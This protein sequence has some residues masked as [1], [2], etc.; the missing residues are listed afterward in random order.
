[1]QFQV[2]H[3]FSY[4]ND[5]EVL[6]TNLSVMADLIIRKKRWSLKRILTIGGITSLVVLASASYFFTSGKSRLNVEPD[7]ITAV[8]VTKRSSYQTDCDSATAAIVPRHDFSKKQA[9]V[10]HQEHYGSSMTF[11]PTLQMLV[12]L[13]KFVRSS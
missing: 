3:G 2:W 11:V 8:T 13:M 4:E 10:T 12:S 9:Q 1:M 5:E 6:Q 7:R